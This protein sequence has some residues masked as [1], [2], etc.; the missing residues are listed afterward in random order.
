[1]R[2]GWA[3]RGWEKDDKH[4]K[5]IKKKLKKRDQ[6]SLQNMR[7]RKNNNRKERNNICHFTMT[8]TVQTFVYRAA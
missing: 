6:I 3:A 5:K 1:M 8:V 2:H 7:L 4:N